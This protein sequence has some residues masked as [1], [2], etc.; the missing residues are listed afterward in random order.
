MRTMQSLRFGA[1]CAALFA[2]VAFAAQ[3]ALAAGKSDEHSAEQRV[4][5]SVGVVQKMKA[6]SKISGVLRQAKGVLIVPDY[7]KVAFGVGGRGGTGVLVAKQANG[8]W[9]DPAFYNT[10]EAS[11]G[12]QA[13]VEGGSVAFLLMSDK[14]L[15]Q[16]KQNNHISLNADAGLSIVDWSAKGQAST[17]KGDVIVWSDTKGLFAGASVGIS[18]LTLSKDETQ[19]YYGGQPVTPRD[20]LAGNTQVRAPATANQLK[21]ALTS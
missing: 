9:S 11:V 1:A 18:D 20:L 13:G 21:Q 4:Q 8:K 16:F 19:A 7:G 5:K 15:D 2:A 12:L 3:P 6:D 17:T 14:A 10:G